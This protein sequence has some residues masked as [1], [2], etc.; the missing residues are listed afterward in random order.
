MAA[1]DLSTTRKA[2]YASAALGVG[3]VDYIVAVFLLKYY[4]DYTGLEAGWAGLALLLGKAF[5][6]ASDPIMGYIS[7]HTR[8]RWGRRRPFVLAG[9]IPLAI[10]FAFMFS[11]S[12]EWSQT[13]LFLWLTA[14]NI[15]YWVGTTMVEVP[16]AAYGSEMT[17]THAQRISLM[18]WREGFKTIGLL[19]GGLIMFSL[20]ESS[21]GAATADAAARGVA[22]DALTEVARFARGEAHHVIATWIGPYILGT[23]LITFLGT[24]EHEGTH[25]PPR[26]TLF[27]D[28]TDTL[29]SGPFRF[30]AFVAIIGQVADGLTATLALYAIGEWWGFGDPHS[31]YILIGYMAMAAL[32]IPVWVRI[33]LHFDKAKMMAAGTFGTTLALIGMLFVPQL[34]LWWAYAMLYFAGVGL[35]GRSVMMVAIIPDIIDDDELHTHT[36]KDGAYFG[37]FSLLRKLSRSLAIGL[38]GLGL[39]FFGYASGVAHQSPDALRGIVIMFCIVPIIFSAVTSVLLLF[40]PIT[41]AHHETT[42]AT[43]RRRRKMTDRTSGMDA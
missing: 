6:A 15:L 30:Y 39:G 17:E 18:G 42:L 19:L 5:D 4:T 24:R 23:T 3:S 14:T 12:P 1:E 11:A 43:L 38:S 25:T 7:D 20:L 40:F 10:S 2:L 9:S 29:R 21:V 8:S 34:G 31:K 26:N 16:H 13:H 28:F 36:R 22:G 32:S 27:G 35:G 33:G 41:R 37:M